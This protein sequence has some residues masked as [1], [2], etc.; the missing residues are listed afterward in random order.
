MA[1]NYSA[2]IQLIV[3]GQQKL[4]KLQNQVTALN[5]QIK[6]LARLDIGGMFEDPLMGGAVAKL[7]AVR[8]EQAAASKQAGQQQDALNRKLENQLLNQIRLNSAVDLY[9]RRLNEVSRTAAPGQE[10]FK[11][12]LEELGQAFQFFKG[13][14]SVTG[15]QAVATELGRI[16]EYS[17]EVTRLEIGRA[18]SSQQIKDYTAQIEKLKTAGLSVTME[19][20]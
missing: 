14:G 16:V 11:G 4:D 5:K 10:Q 9:Q 8:N 13:K 19:A 18:K 7:R 2:T 3:E 17:R 6:E 20:N 15:V 12:R 1:A